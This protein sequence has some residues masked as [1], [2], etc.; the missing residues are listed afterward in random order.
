[1]GLGSCGEL[2]PSRV[3]AGRVQ[4]V[5]PDRVSQV[6]LPGKPCRNTPICK[7]GAGHRRH[8][9]FA[10]LTRQAP[11]PPGRSAAL[12]CAHADRTLLLARGQQVESHASSCRPCSTVARWWTW[13][14]C[15]PPR[16]EIL[17]ARASNCPAVDPLPGPIG[18]GAAAQPERGFRAALEDA[19]VPVQ[20]LIERDP[21]LAIFQV[22]RQSGNAD[23]AY[24]AQRSLQTR[25]HQPS[26]WPAPG[27]D[28]RADGTRPSRSPDDEPGDAGTA[29]PAGAPGTAP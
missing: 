21:D 25:H 17:K 26:W 20:S 19:A 15:R 13:P 10:E 12:Q 18:A 3:P 8:M 24:G 4:P 22:L 7:T 2:K 1:M 29:G 9:Q 27:L 16:E 14:S 5:G 6:K 11:H 23:T 28:G